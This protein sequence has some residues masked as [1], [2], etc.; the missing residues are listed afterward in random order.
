VAE[1]HIERFLSCEDYTGR[2]N[3]VIS[4]QSWVLLQF[5]I[6]GL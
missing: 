4:P 6:H 5:E 2:R 1:K 3:L